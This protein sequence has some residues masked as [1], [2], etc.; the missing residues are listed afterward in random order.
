MTA[1]LRAVLP[2]DIGRVVAV[3]DLDVRYTLVGPVQQNE[4]PATGFPK[5]VPVA[6]VTLRPGAQR[7]PN[8]RGERSDVVTRRRLGRG[9]IVFSA[10]TLR[11]LFSAPGK[12]VDFFQDVFHLKEVAKSEQSPPTPVSLFESIAGRVSFSRSANLYLLIVGAVSIGYVLMATF[13]SWGFLR[14]RRWTHHS[15]SVFALLGLLAS[16]LTVGSVQSVRGFGARLHQLS[17]ID[18]DAGE[19]YGD[20]TVLFGLRSGSDQRMDVWLPSDPLRATEPG[21]TECFLR[22]LPGASDASS[23]YSSFTDPGEYRLVPAS[24]VVN[25]VRLRATLKLLEGRWNGPLGGKLTGRVRVHGKRLTDDSYVTNELG[26]DLHDCMLLQP[27][28]EKR[29]TAVGG[30]QDV[31]CYA[32]GDIP[33]DGSIVN[34]AS[35]CYGQA[36]EEALDKLIADATLRKSQSEWSKGFRSILARTGFG[37]G[38]EWTGAAGLEYGALLLLS[39]IDEFDPATL[40]NSAELWMGRHT[41][42]RDRLRRLDLGEQLEPGSVFLIGV[43]D[44]GGPVRLF[45]REGDRAYRVLRPDAA[46]SR[47]IYRIRIRVGMPTTGKERS[48][49]PS[50]KKQ[51]KEPVR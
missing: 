7:V 24:A 23:R 48:T 41:W 32:I 46:M 35:R 2:V 45:R 40:G 33:S 43:A 49:P 47:A 3:H 26:V 14:A 25:N 1:P 29:R 22:P 5:P 44:S 36:D 9:W 15:W 11:D 16:A 31:L 51:A 42:S 38:G 37:A 30:D 6:Q 18:A 13:G 39:T 17:V 34:L 28:A 12:A 27:T 8:H 50:G 21:A 20:A 4:D 10:V 19:T